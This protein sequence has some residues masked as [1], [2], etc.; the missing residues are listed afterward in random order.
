LHYQV[1][2]PQAKLVRVIEGEVLD[3]A[4]DLRKNSSTYGQHFSLL[5]SG[6]NKKQLFR[7]TE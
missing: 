2:K 1:V 3:V 6:E 7:R 4:V 5:L